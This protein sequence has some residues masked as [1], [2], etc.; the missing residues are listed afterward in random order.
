MSTFLTSAFK[1]IKYRLAT[2]SDPL[3]TVAWSKSFQ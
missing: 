2:K 3:S 1:A